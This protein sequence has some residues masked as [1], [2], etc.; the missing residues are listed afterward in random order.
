MHIDRDD[1]HTYDFQINPFSFEREASLADDKKEILLEDI[2]RLRI[3]LLPCSDHRYPQYAGA[4]LIST[5]PLSF[6]PRF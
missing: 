2:A 6:S 5:S 1:I 3:G 4:M